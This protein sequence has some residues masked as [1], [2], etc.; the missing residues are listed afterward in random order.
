MQHIVL[1]AG[2]AG[3]GKTEFSKQVAARLRWP[4][5]DKDTLTRPMVEALCGFLCND[6]HDRQSAPYIEAIRPLEY[7]VL[8]EVMWEILDLGA[9]GVV[10]TGPFVTELQD[11]AWLDDFAFDCELKG[12]LLYLV[13]V[14]CDTDS[15]RARLVA[16][17]AE[18]DRWKLLHWSAWSETLVRPRLP[19]GA[20]LVDNSVDSV[21]P[22]FVAVEELLAR[23]SNA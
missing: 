11:N 3:S 18:R 1:V 20:L 23:V 12:C 2:Y 15:L 6:P 16:R 5:L 21:C 19:E 17:G 8:L 7:Q 10:V 4:L 9:P 22:M 13:W 14:Q